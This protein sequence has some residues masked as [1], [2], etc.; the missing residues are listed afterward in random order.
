[1]PTASRTAVCSL[2]TPEEYSSGIVQ[3]PNSAN[4]APSASWRS[5]RGERLPSAMARTY[6]VRV[7]EVPSYTLRNANPAK[8]RCDAVVVGLVS[9]SKGATVAE[10][11]EDVAKA[12]GRK[13][14]PLLVTLGATGKA[15][16]VLRVPGGDA[17]NAGLVVFVGLGKPERGGARVAT[18]RTPRGRCRRPGRD[19]RRVGGARAPRRHPRAAPGRGRG[20]RPGRLHLH[21]VQEGP[22]DDDKKAH[23]GEVVL[24]SPGARRA[25]MQTVVDEAQVVADAVAGARDWVN[26]PPGD[27]TP[28]AFADAVVEAAKAASKG[29]GAR[30]V[31]ATVIDEKQLATSWA[32]AASSA[33]AAARPRRRGWS[34]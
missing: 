33:S 26:T 18:G 29:R 32:A 15:G 16:E 34:S 10:G 8:T 13:L 12:Y 19:Q 5:C 14:R 2:T 4:F 9:T 23:P 7:A 28:P 21:G 1:M 22:N 17:T 11:G 20:L 3:P 27:F 31:D 30:K 25:E 24:L 6:L